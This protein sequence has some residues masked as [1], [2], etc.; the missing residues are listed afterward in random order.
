[1]WYV[2]TMQCFS[3]MKA[4]KL[5]MHDETW[6]DLKNV[7]LCERSQT[8]QTAHC[9]KLFIKMKNVQKKANLD[10]ADYWLLGEWGGRNG[11]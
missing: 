5:Q 3:A 6:M 9:M 8:Q 1:M 10:K 4:S 2:H 7:L 11:D